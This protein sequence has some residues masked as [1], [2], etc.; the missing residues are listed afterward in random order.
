M[1]D[2][3]ECF[4]QLVQLFLSGDQPKNMQEYLMECG[5]SESEFLGRKAF[6]DF[7]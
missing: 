1:G 5:V 6:S 2:E 4:P 7:I 3:Q